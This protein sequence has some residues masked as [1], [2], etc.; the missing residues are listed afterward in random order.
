MLLYN[1]RAAPGLG[2]GD[3]GVSFSRS[4]Q[5]LSPW[6]AR[7]RH[8]AATSAGDVAADAAA[9]EGLAGA[10][11]GGVLKPSAGWPPKAG[12]PPKLGLPC[13]L[14]AGADADGDAGSSF[15]TGAGAP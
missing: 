13:A 9:A 12:A 4:R 11:R 8:S 15:G 5:A 2:A 7:A 3:S 10:A 6:S 1:F 14:P